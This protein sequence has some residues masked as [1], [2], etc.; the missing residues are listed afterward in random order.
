MT[1]FPDLYGL[2]PDAEDPKPLLPDMNQVLARLV[3]RLERLPTEDELAE[4]LVEVF[5]GHRRALEAWHRRH[6]A[7]MA[8]RCPNVRTGP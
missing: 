5:D 8:A 7:R 2:D 6:T 1:T 4:E 3:E